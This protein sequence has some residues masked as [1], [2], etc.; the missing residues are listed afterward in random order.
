MNQIPFALDR[1]FDELRIFGCVLPKKGHVARKDRE[2]AMIQLTEEQS[3][4]LRNGEPVRLPLCDLGQ[5]VVLLRGQ[6]F[7]RIQML[8]EDDR[9]KAAWAALGRKAAGRWAQENPY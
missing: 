2:N 1:P 5:E 6:D 7:A 9:E 3:Q 4:A 8:L